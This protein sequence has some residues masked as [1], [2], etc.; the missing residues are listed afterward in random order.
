VYVPAPFRP[1]SQGQVFDVID[2]H[3]FATVVTADPGGGVPTVTHLPLLLDRGR[4]GQGTLVGHLARANPHAE[5]L[6]LGSPTVA[7]F[8]GPYGYVS[9]S[10]YRQE[11]SLPTWN[12]VAVHAAGTPAL[13]DD[14]HHLLR[15]LSRTVDVLEAS[16]GEAQ[17]W[18]LDQE[19][20]YV[21]GYLG[22]IVAF[23]LAIES[24]Q[25]MIKLSQNLDESLRSRVIDGLRRRDHHGDRE[26]ADAMQEDAIHEH[27]AVDGPKDR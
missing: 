12:Y 3:P 9:P 19:S 15:L 7:V 21:V 6:R 1:H 26:L 18:V 27:V 8:H 23:E 22:P 20:D 10:W 16:G 17:P 4:G 14:P 11:P 2:S 24:L 25:A 5:L 13:V